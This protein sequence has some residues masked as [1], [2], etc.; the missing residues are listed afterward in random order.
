MM[1]IVHDALRRD[2]ARAVAALST[3]LEPPR[4]DAVARHVDWMMDFL[5]AHHAGEDAGLWPVLRERRPECGSLVDEMEAD[6]RLIAPAIEAVVVAA[7]HPFF[8]RPAH[9][10]LF[11][12]GDC[13]T[14]EHARYDFGRNAR[15]TDSCVV[16]YGPSTRSMQ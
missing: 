11:P 14:G 12:S 7:P 10:P 5:H 16:R 2:L 13:W 8:L 15:T 1:G 4:L 3:D 6:H 9:R